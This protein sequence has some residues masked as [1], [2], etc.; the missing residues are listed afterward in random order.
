[1][2]LQLTKLCPSFW[3]KRPKPPLSKWK[4]TVQPATNPW[5][6]KPNCQALKIQMQSKSASSPINLT[7]GFF[8]QAFW[9]ERKK[10]GK[11]NFR[12]VWQEYYQWSLVPQLKA[13]NPNR[14]TTTSAS[15]QENGLQMRIPP[16]SQILAFYKPVPPGSHAK[17]NELSLY[18]A[19]TT[20]AQVKLT[21]NFHIGFTKRQHWEAWSPLTH[22]D[23]DYHRADTEPEDT[24]IKPPEVHRIA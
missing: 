24:K 9:W 19:R 23:G 17:E 20:S 4:L 22:Q 14:D 2:H 13:Q 10:R 21:P 7:T 18:P 12:Q 15:Y 1:M 11:Y 8:F 3:A 16:Q 6:L 5:T